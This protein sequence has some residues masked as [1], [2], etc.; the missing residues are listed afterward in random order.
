MDSKILSNI[1]NHIKDEDLKKKILS[2][3]TEE[4]KV[5]EYFIQNISVGTL[6]AIRELKFLHRINDPKAV[7]RKLIEKGLVEQGYGCY[8]LSKTLRDVLYSI[9]A[10]SKE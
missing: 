9:I 7:I 5:L 3:S 6:V 1:I 4:V 8:S 10:S 2:L